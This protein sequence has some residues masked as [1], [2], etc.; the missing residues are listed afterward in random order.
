MAQI[1]KN[2]VK[3]DNQL[4]NRS[5][6][7]FENENNNGIRVLFVGNSITRHSPKEDIGWFNDWGMAASSKENDYVHVVKAK[8]LKT[9]PDASFC[10]CQAAKWE[11]NYIN[12]ETQLEDFGIARD[13]DADI[14][15]IRLIENC[16]HKNFE[17]EIFETQYK[18]FVSYFNKSGKA[19]TIV[20]TGFW[21]H[22]GDS[23]I[24][25][26]AKDMD[27]PCIN[28]GE[29]GEQS[30]MRADGLFEHSGVAAHP[31]DKGMAAIADLIYTEAEKIL[32]AKK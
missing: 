20:T 21:K 3:A 1:D 19:S 15:I 6:I 27:I 9:N 25:K 32:I 18:K 5:Y 14:I 22:P 31:S 7:T 16:P 10:I 13:F 8:V 28:L 12:G 29:L 2:T 4:G 17:P 23:I 11:S 30:D 26:A 24:I